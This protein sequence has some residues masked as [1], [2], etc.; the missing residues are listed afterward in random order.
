MTAMRSAHYFALLVI[1]VSLARTCYG[2]GEYCTL[3]DCSGPGEICVEGNCA[4]DSSTHYQAQGGTQCSAKGTSIGGA[5]TV[6]GIGSIGSACSASN[7]QC[8]GSSGEGQGTCSCL[9]GNYQSATNVCSPRGDY[10][11]TTHQSVR[12]SVLSVCPSG[13]KG[14]SIGGAC[15]VPGIGSIGSACSASNSQCTGSSGEGQGTCSCLSGNYQSATNVC[16]PRGDY[17]LTTHQSVRLSVLSVC[18]SGKKGTS[19]GGA[20]TVP[21]IG[22]VGPACSASNSQCTGSSG[23]GQGTCSCLSGN[24]QS[25]TNVCS[26][27]GDYMLTTHQSVRLSVLSVC[28]SGKKGTSIG[29][30][31]TVPGIGSIGSACSASNSQCTGSSGEGQ[32][33]C[34]CL[35]GNYQSA[36]NVCSPRGDYRLT[37]HQSVRLSVLSVCP[38]GKKGTSIGGA[39]TV[40][41]I[42]SI[43]SACS[44]SNSQCTGSSGEGQ[45]TCSCLSGN[46]QSATNIC[47]PRGD[48]RLTTHQSVRLSVLSVCPS[49]K[50]GTS[51]GGACTVPGIGSVGPACSASNSQCTGSSGEGQ[52]T[53]SCLSGN[54]QSAT[55]VC[56]PRGDYRLT[57]HQSIRLSVLSVCPSGKKGTSIGGACTVPGIGSI[58]SACSASNSQCTWSSGEG[59]GTCSCLSGNYQSATNVCSPIGTSIGGSCTVPASTGSSGSPCS[60]PASQCTGSSGEGLGKC[61]C[62][63]Q[64]YQSATNMCS[65]IGTT[66]G[67]SCTKP[68][69]GSIG[70]ACSAPA[71]QC[72]GSSGEGAGRCSCLSGNY[73]SATNVCSTIGTTIGGSCTQPGT[74]SVGSACSVQNSQCTGSIGEGLG[75][76]SCSDQNNQSAT[77]MCSPIGT[78]IGVSCTKPSSGSIGSPCSAPASQCTGTSGEGAGTCSCL[79]GYYPSATNVCSTIGTSIGVSC[80]KP[81]SGS[82]GSPCSAPASQCTGTSGEGAG[83]C[84]CLIGYYPSAT[85]VCSTKGTSIGGACTVPGIGSVGP[86]C[87]ASNSQCTGSSGEGQGT[88]S[89]LSGNYQSATNVCSPRGD[90]RLTTHQSVRL[91]VLSVCPSGKKGTSIGGACT[92]PGIGSIGSACSASNSQCTGSSGEGQGTCSCLS[93]NY[94]SATNIC[95]PRGDYRLTTHQSVRL[96]VLSVCPSGK[97]G[98]SI[99]GACTVPGI[100]SVGLACSA[101]NSQCTGSSGE[102]QGT[103]SCLSG[104]YQSATNVCSPRGDYRLTTHQSIRLSV[105]SVCPSGKKGTSIG[106][107][108]TVPGIGSIGSACS[109]SNSQCTWSSGEGQ[110][111]CSCLSGNYQSATNVCS[112]IGTSIGGSCTVPASTGSSGSPCSAPASQCTGSSGEGLGKCSCSDQNYQ[113][114]TNMC[115]PIGTTIGGSC[116]KP[117]TGSIGSACS[118]PASQCTGSSGEGA[119]RCSCLSGNYQSATNVCSTIGT[120]IGGSCTQPGTGSVGS[121]CSV[122]NSQC[123]GSIGEGLGKCSCS[124]Q[125][126]QSATNMC[127]PIGTSI[128]VSCTKPSSGSIGSPCSA[129]A[130][131]CTGTSGEGAGTCSCLIGYYPSATNVCS[132]KVGLGSQCTMKSAC[133]NENSDCL[134]HQSGSGSTCQCT[135][136]YFDTNTVDNIQGLCIRKITLDSRC[137][138]SHSNLAQCAADNAICDSRYSYACK[139]RYGYYVDPSNPAKC[140]ARQPLGGV[141]QYNTDCTDPNAECSSSKCRCVDGFYDTNGIDM[142]G[143]CK[144]VAELRVTNINFQGISTSQFSVSWDI[145]DGKAQYI[146][147]FVVEWMPKGN[148]IGGGTKM[149]S[150]S[151]TTALL[152]SGISAGKSYTVKITSI[153]S[154]LGVNRSDFSSTDQDAKPNPPTWDAATD[155]NPDIDNTIIVSWIAPLGSVSRYEVSLIDRSTTVVLTVVLHPSTSTNL[156]SINIKNGYSY[157]IQIISKSQSNTVESDPLTYVIKTEV[158]VPDPPTGANCKEVADEFITVEWNAPAVPNGDLRQYYIHVHNSSRLVKIV[159][160]DTVVNELKVLHL[161][162]VTYYNFRVYT[163]NEKYNSSLYG[164]S[165]SC[166]TKAKISEAPQDLAITGVTSRAFTVSWERPNN[167]YSEEFLG[168]VLQIK[169]GDSCVQEIKYKCSNCKRSFDS[170]PT[171]SKVCIRGD[172][173]DESKSNAELQNSTL[174]LSNNTFK[175]DTDYTVLVAAVNDIGWGHQAVQSVKSKEEEPQEPPKA[176]IVSDIGK[177]SF[178]VSWSLNGP[179]PGQVTYTVIL[180]ADTGAENKTYTVEGYDNT[181]RFADG[182]EEYWNYTVSVTARTN[183]GGAKTSYTTQKYRTLPSAPG[184]VTEFGPVKAHLRSDNFHKMTIQWKAPLLLQRNSVIKEYVLKYNVGNTTASSGVGGRFKT[185][186]FTSETGDGFYSKVFDVIPESSYQFEVRL[187]GRM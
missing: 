42:G 110:G 28:P 67:G 6:P 117:G 85:N 115:S 175:P 82:I 158:I 84:S 125:N 156:T 136:D 77:N 74:G 171:S 50:K 123:T 53:C 78:S 91:S 176:V 129:P 70:S 100:G 51:I 114:A 160:T 61:S 157:T 54:Y 154:Q 108:C 25:A 141:C 4:C 66:I 179:R 71:S 45:G 92:V 11:L 9:S 146:Q 178:N 35:S 182:L 132:T 27:R 75:K 119:G 143:T 155:I 65:P 81:S 166:P 151:F 88:C 10:R 3:G 19:I 170:A 37:T 58:G 46:Y 153:N 118:A 76:C 5:C 165:P 90:Y 87:S 109:A 150:S 34:S 128:G 95:S 172:R 102:G 134:G 107:A 164:Q 36:T 101:S 56:S 106:G 16:S 7:S 21:G 138:T 135:S 131:Q 72:T 163:E 17:R 52:G 97:K 31:C 1:F 15:T 64:N 145:P 20:C 127:S 162:P 8:T 94:Q 47:S 26:P 186:S 38:S 112:P 59:Q 169:E 144:S 168:Y 83:T 183:V 12:L 49:G 68:G 174:T 33:T 23:E 159:G 149:L 121:A 80:T 2:I 122:Q 133:L 111:T 140:K 43:G 148:T 40:P 120:T 48:Y 152:D 180:T 104:N 18:P 142:D 89:C 79:I 29:G 14:T 173:M 124:D 130:S 24:Y 86:A 62:S 32:G 139:C 57:T 105:L 167:T 98:T 30:A 185:I 177:T 44:A 22:S 69:T 147:T 116:T 126:Y 137:D 55:N 93:G 73:Q 63:D 13:K 187:S 96:S 60:A 184:N 181:S 99:G 39:C 113:S 103:C 161:K 41:G